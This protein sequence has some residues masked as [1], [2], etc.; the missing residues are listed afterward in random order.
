MGFLRKIHLPSFPS[1]EQFVQT[2]PQQSPDPVLNTKHTQDSY[3]S[4]EERQGLTRGLHSNQELQRDLSCCILTC[5]MTAAP[6]HI[7]QD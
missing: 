3:V 2:F 6:Q 5:Q 4:T 1:I 7:S